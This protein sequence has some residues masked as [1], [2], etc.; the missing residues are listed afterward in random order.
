MLR[1]ELRRFKEIM[2]TRKADQCTQTVEEQSV[3]SGAMV[4][5]KIFITL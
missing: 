4:N 3:V 2:N 1:K 5:F